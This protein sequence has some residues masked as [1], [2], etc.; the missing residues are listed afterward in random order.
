MSEDESEGVALL[1]LGE[2]LLSAHDVGTGNASPSTFTRPVACA[3]LPPGWECRIDERVGRS[4]FVNHNTKQTTFEDP[5]GP[6]YPQGQPSE[7]DDDGSGSAIPRW[8]PQPGERVFVF[9]KMDRAFRRCP[10]SIVGVAEPCFTPTCDCRRFHVEWGPQGATADRGELI[11]V[12]T[13]AGPTVAVSLKD[14][15][16]MQSYGVGQ[17]MIVNS[18]SAST[19]RFQNYAAWELQ[20]VEHVDGR[21]GQHTDHLGEEL[22]FHG[23]TPGRQVSL[24]RTP[25]EKVNLIGFAVSEGGRRLE[26]IVSDVA[27]GRRRNMDARELQGRALQRNPRS[28]VMC[29]ADGRTR[30]A[31]SPEGHIWTTEISDT[32]L[33]W[34][35]CC[36]SCFALCFKGCWS[37]TKCVNCGAIKPS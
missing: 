6:Q 23:L 18:N 13:D 32:K 19:W 3:G 29:D 25:A 36:N 14:L 8:G 35:I 10:G 15:G 1:S 21:T 20:T 12:R 28:I 24:A 5:R 33:C 22:K 34:C 26:T 2:S 9:A 37:K 27:T 11:F 4:F 30:A 16:R 17:Q 31:Q 7:R